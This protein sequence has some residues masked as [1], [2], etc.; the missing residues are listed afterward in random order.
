[1]STQYL[2]FGQPDAGKGGSDN[3]SARIFKRIFAGIL[4]IVIPKANPDF[5]RLIDQVDI[6]L[7]EIDEE[8]ELPVREIGIDSDGRVLMK[9]PFERNVGY[10]TGQQFK[11]SGFQGPVWRRYNFEGCV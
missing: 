4:T 1:M 10:W 9:M 3:R 8:E 2:K 5:E 11:I 7:V 6:W